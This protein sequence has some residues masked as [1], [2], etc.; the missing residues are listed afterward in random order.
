M[1][2][3]KLEIKS[4]FMR[5]LNIQFT[6]VVP[7]FALILSQLQVKFNIF[8]LPYNFFA[9]FIHVRN[10]LLKGEVNFMILEP[11]LVIKAPE[12]YCFLSNG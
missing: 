7:L 1:F 6:K 9:S 8:I 4:D 5:L 2:S 12:I 11:L 10:F 3:T